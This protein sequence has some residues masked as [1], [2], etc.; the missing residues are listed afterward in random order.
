MACFAPLYGIAFLSLHANC[1]PHSTYNVKEN[2]VSQAIL[3][4]REKVGVRNQC[5][6][7][8]PLHVEMQHLLFK[9]IKY[10]IHNTLRTKSVEKLKS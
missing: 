9:M 3:E 1:F 7:N 10:C 4:E 8:F 6:R 5:K 2:P